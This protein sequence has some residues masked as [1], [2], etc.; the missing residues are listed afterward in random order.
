MTAQELAADATP[1]SYLFVLKSLSPAQ[2]IVQAAHAAI[3][4]GK[5]LSPDPTHPHLVLI[6]LSR[7]DMHRLLLQLENRDVK[8]CEFREPAA[9]NELTAVIT[10]PLVGL[11]RKW[12]QKYQLLSED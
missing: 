4:L 1:Y 12:L 5:Q 11:D 10:H 2:R 3:E 8:F 7:A 9:D 6:G